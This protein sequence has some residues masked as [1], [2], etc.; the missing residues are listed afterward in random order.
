MWVRKSDIEL[1][2]VQDKERKSLRG[3][4]YVFLI[5]IVVIMSPYGRYRSKPASDKYDYMVFAILSSSI[6]AGTFHLLQRHVL[7]RDI[8]KR[9]GLL[10]CETC[11][12]SQA[13]NKNR[14]C[15]HCGI[16]IEELQKYK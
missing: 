5:S 11:N 9:P 3:F 4:L 7:K 2:T 1:K 10:H 12:K 15:N 16:G 8:F 14:T 13:A 6:I